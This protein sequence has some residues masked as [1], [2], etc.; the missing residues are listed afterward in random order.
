MN[1][2]VYFMWSDYCSVKSCGQCLIE[3]LRKGL[4]CN[5]VH[6]F[7]YFSKMASDR[8]NLENYFRKELETRNT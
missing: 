2:K 1:G 3:A 8:L 6:Y 5:N 7:Y 4:V